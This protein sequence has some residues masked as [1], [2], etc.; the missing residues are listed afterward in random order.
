[1]QNLRN[2]FVQTLRK[3][4]LVYASL[5]VC[6][7]CLNGVSASRGYLFADLGH[8]KGTSRIFSDFYRSKRN[9]LISVGG[10]FVFFLAPGIELPVAVVS[11]APYLKFTSILW[12]YGLI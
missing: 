12:Q 5:F 11:A 3:K 2:Y 10:Y 9:L 1:M 8:L 7:F 4:S 6:R